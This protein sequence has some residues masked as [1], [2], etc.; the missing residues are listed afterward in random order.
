MIE[1]IFLLIFFFSFVA[2]I[3]GLINPSL[4]K[5]KSRKMALLIF[6]GGAFVFFIIAA[7]TAPPV[8]KESV[9]EITNQEN[10]PSTQ[11]TTNSTVNT[12]TESNQEPSTADSASTAIQST[13][14]TAVPVATKSEAPANTQSVTLYNVIKVVD[15]DTIDV[16]INGKTKR[17]RLIGINTPETVDPRT[18]VQCFG[19]EASDKA[20]ELLTGKKVSLEADSTQ[21]ELD[22]YSR[23]LRYVFL[24]DGTNFN[25]YMIK[26]GYAYE[27]TYSTPYKYQVEFKAAQV[28]AKANNKGLWSPSTCNGELKAATQA[29]TTTTSQSSTTFGACGTKATC[30]QMT[31]CEEAKY[32][33]NTCGVIKLDGDSDG[34]PC[35]SLCS[36]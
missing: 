26:E 30:S 7:F 16:S 25:L 8:A 4:V 18:V 29:Q 21:G 36:D 34:T 2:L 28:Y 5:M 24:E 31:S 14:A 32:F 15:G 19:K 10:T 12:P 33:L 17:L 9:T 3:A 13:A 27:Y 1:Y 6:G 35:E 11:E 23:L 22:K 20:K